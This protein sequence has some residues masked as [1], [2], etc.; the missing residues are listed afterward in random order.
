M[1]VDNAIDEPSL[2]RNNKDNDFGNNNLY[3]KNSINLN[4]QAVNDNQVITKSYIDQFHQENERSR[5]D[6]GLDFYDEADDLE[7]KIQDNDL[8]DD[9]LTNINLITFNNSPTDDSHVSNKKYIDDGLDKNTFVRFNETLENYLKVSVGNDIYNLTKYNK[10]H[11]TDITVIIAGNNGLSLL[12]NWRF[13]CNDKNIS[14][15]ISNFIKSTKTKSPTGDSGSTTLPP[16]GSAFLYIETSSNNDGKK[17][18]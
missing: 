18:L 2:E 6:V 8:N 16:I 3:N 5:R 15:K 12:P 9:K 4:T 11:L 14:G 13:V 7:K 17:F 1:Y 10:F